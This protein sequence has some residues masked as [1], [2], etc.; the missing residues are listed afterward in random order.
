LADVRLARLTGIENK[1][2]RLDAVLRRLSVVDHRFF[3]V[4]VGLTAAGLTL[5]MAALL[6]QSGQMAA[7]VIAGFI[8]L[9]IG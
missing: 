3:L 7:G 5:L 9:F 8:V 4:R 2:E 6:M 1:I